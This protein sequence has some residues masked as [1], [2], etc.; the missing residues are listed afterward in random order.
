MTTP[1]TQ[2]KQIAAMK[3]KIDRT[4]DLLARIDERQ[5]NHDKL[6]HSIEAQTKKKNGRVTRLE[7]WKTLMIGI[8]MGI[9]ILFGIGIT[10]LTLYLKFM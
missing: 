9:N 1:C 4:E 6:L 10:F 3:A 5:Q 8:S 7:L 2:E